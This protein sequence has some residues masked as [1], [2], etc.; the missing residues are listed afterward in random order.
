MSI[1]DAFPRVHLL[2]RPQVRGLKL[3][4]VFSFYI[5]N[6]II[7]MCLIV[8]YTIGMLESGPKETSIFVG[9][10]ASSPG[11]THSELFAELL[12]DKHIATHRY[13]GTQMSEVYSITL[14]CLYTDVF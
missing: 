13:S 5:G 2:L 8:P 7:W 11:L 1:G 4:Q 6:V 12:Q 10:P 9:I 3:S 14:K